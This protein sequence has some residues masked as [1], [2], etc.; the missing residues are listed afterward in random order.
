M[1]KLF[2]CH[3]HILPGIDDGAK[4][5]ETSIE[6]IKNMKDLGFES[7]VLTPHYRGNMI[8]NNKVKK[9]LLNTL[10]LELDKENIDINLYLANEVHIT[11]QLLD[12][13]KNDEI[14]LLGNYLF[15]ELPF[16]TKIH[17]L[18]KVI[19]ELQDNDINIILVH[20]ERYT[21]LNKEDFE[22]LHDADI[23]FQVNYESII[24][25]YGIKSK[26]IVKYLYKNNLV[27]LLA[28]DVHR[29]TTP[30]FSKYDSIKKKIIKLIGER[31]YEDITY[32]NMNKIIEEIQ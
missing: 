13:I 32:N 5:V 12:K 15:L 16:N 9:I 19:Y 4:D 17:N 29:P 27:D 6:I 14:S 11:S 25:K 1:N 24:G 26:N 10:K 21:Y 30:L 28:T 31:K 20:P 18:D 7:I 2:D 23:L 22:K 8:A 3:S